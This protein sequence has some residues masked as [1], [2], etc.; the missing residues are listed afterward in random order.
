MP[1]P[2]DN[3]LLTEIRNALRFLISQQTGGIAPESEGGVPYEEQ[4]EQH[5]N[6]VDA[7]LRGDF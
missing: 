1:N 7:I 3:E 6:H 2:S 4:V 5:R